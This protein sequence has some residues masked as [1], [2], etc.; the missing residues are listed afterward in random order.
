MS[1]KVFR[2]VTQKGTRFDVIPRLDPVCC[3]FHIPGMIL[4]LTTEETRDF[5]LAF[6]RC[7]QAKKREEEKCCVEK[8]EK[9]GEGV[10]KKT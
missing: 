10:E 8:V 3:E 7:V 9:R 5:A 1:I 4:T 2:I 6:R